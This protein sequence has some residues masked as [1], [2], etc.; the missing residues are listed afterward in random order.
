MNRTRYF[1]LIIK[2]FLLGITVLL[3]APG[4]SLAA[5]KTVT[6]KVY[7]GYNFIEKTIT[8]NGAKNTDLSF[9]VNSGRQG[10]L[11]FALGALGARRIKEFGRNKPA[12]EDIS[13]PAVKNWKTYANAPEEGYYILQGKDEA[14]LYLIKV[15]AFK[16][17]GKAASLWELTFSWERL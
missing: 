14:T 8:K 11:S 16:N 5:D 3:L 13:M 1:K 12:A 17:Q 15:L 2:G 6:L 7:Q 4:Q 9:Y 10:S